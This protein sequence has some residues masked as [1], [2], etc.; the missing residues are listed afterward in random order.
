MVTDNLPVLGSEPPLVGRLN[1]LLRRLQTSEPIVKVRTPA[2]DEAWF[3]TRYAEV[4]RLLLDPRLGRSHPDPANM[5]RY[6]DSALLDMLVTTTDPEADRLA[7]AHMRS[8]LTPLFTAKRMAALRPK[9]AERVRDAVDAVLAQGPPADMHAQFTFPLSFGVLCDLLGMPETDEY[10]TI[11]AGVTT[12]GNLAE[13][14]EPGPLAAMQYLAKVAARRREC[15]GDDV[16]SALCSAHPDDFFVASAASLLT[17]TYQATPTTLSASVAILAAH[18]DQRD[19]LI[20]DPSLLHT[21]VE[22]ALRMGKVGESFVPRYATEDIDIGGV[23]IKLGDLVL[24]D[25]FSASLDERVFA[26]PER[27]DITRSPNPHLA[28][29]R[30]AWH[31]IGAPLAQ[32]EIEEVFPALLSRMP[33]IRLT[34]PLEELAVKSGEQFSA[35]IGS[36]PVTW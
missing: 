2:G 20:K 36:V 10:W 14:S 34:V 33:G 32:I 22:E 23:T 7:H 15:P 18:P 11:L 30:G 3:V 29:S 16:I 28:F 31:C 13:G 1:P 6:Y 21:A 27:F 19:L 12:V 35:G 8:A 5:P 24:C 17:F 4:K 26:E 9:V 25:H